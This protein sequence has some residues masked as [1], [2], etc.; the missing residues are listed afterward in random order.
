LY[1]NNSS[2]QPE[3]S[4]LFPEVSG[5]GIIEQ[6]GNP[7]QSMTTP[8]T[9]LIESELQE[10]DQFLLLDVQSD[11]S[12]TSDT[13]DGYLHA[14]AIGPTS[15]TPQQW[16][17]GIWGEGDSMMPPVKSIELLNRIL[18]LIMRHFNG[19]ITGF[20]QQ[21]RE[22]YPIWCTSEYRGKEYDDAEGWAYGFTEGMKLCLNDW[23]PLLKTPQGQ[24][25]YRSIG[26]LGE[27]E[28]SPEQDKLTKTP[29]QRGKLALQI[30][31]AIVAMFEYWL[32]Y[33]QAVY[34]REV[35]KT[36]QPQVGRSEE[37][38]CGSGKK[39]Q[40]CCGSASVLH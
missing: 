35:A 1:C 37:C 40:N 39:Y 14:I 28:F 32:P 27:D 10:L 36:L 24:D 12:M 7:A 16:M 2:I 6:R 33:R 5:S 11:E 22:I 13:L 20:E 38:P 29:A 26:L 34:E 30:P 31:E 25:W 21:P 17:P 4:H 15:L 18:S 9:P 19:I 8:F 23:D 3:S